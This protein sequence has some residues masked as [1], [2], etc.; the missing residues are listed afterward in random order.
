MRMSVDIGGTFTDLVVEDGTGLS[1]YK[2]PTVPSDPVQG[3]LDVLGTAATARDVPLAELLGKVG[4]FVHATTRG[5]NA[6]LTGN[7]ARTAFLTTAGHPDVLL[8]REGGRQDA[9]DFTVPFPEPYVPRALTFEVTERITSTGEVLTALDLDAL[10]RTCDQLVAADVE[11]IAVCLLWSTVNPEHELAVGEVLDRRLPGVPHTLSHALN[12]SLREYRRASSAAIDASLKP[13]MS[14]YFSALTERLR[15]AGLRGRIL[16]VTSAG[17]VI[18]AA[19]AVARPILTINSGPSMAPVAG[20]A[21]ALADTGSDDVI[22]ADAGGTTYDVTLV[23][24]GEIP[25]TRSAWVGDVGTGHMTGL[26]SIDVKSVGSGGGSIAWVDEGGLLHVGPQSA[27]SVPG[28]AC[29][30]RGGRSATVTDAALVLGYLDADGFSSGAMTLDAEAAVVAVKTSVADVLGIDVIEAADAILQLTTEQMVRAIEEIT[31]GQGID[32]A[33]AVLIG[34]GGAAGLNAHAVAERLGCRTLVVPAVGAALAA[35]G[36]L[37]SDLTAI[38]SATAPTITS[39]FAIERV[40][41][42]LAELVEQGREFARKAGVAPEEA[43]IALFAE[44]RYPQQIWELEVPLRV[45]AF[46]GPDDVADL[47]EDFHRTHLEIL[48]ITDPASP[49]EIVSW[50]ARVTVRLEE[51]NHQVGALPRGSAEITRRRAFVPGRGITD[52]PV[53]PLAAMEPGRPVRGPLLVEAPFTTVVV[54]GDAQCRIGESG[55]LVIETE[56]DRPEKED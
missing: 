34:G 20:R 51:A 17:G 40:D 21:Y 1:L 10:E 49:V 6:V 26:P 39:S 13:L 42:A 18:D 48:G 45:T 35:A 53:V 22:V 36:A 30:G 56:T 4:A 54:A 28:P 16:M 47:A 15:D 50:G 11:A 3:I 5:L 33:K 8:L 55:S 24:R 2:A 31:V 38:Y 7:A 9:F 27:G 32:P 52:V 46:A 25:S 19:D 23:R 44:A 29:Y 12:P 14:D 43:T 41:A 37:M